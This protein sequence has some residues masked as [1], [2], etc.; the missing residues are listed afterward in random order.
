MD[1]LFKIS[2][3]LN[4]KEIAK[5]RK[6]LASPFFEVPNYIQEFGKKW[7]QLCEATDWHPLEKEEAWYGIYGSKPFDDRFW[8]KRKSEL[9]K[10][11]ERFI[12]QNHYTTNS[13]HQTVE[14][15]RQ[16]SERNLSKLFE[17]K[18]ETA[19]K[20]Q[21]TTVYRSE[22]DIRKRIEI[23][24]IGYNHHIN[25]QDPNKPNAIEG[26]LLKIR[27]KL[28]HDLYLFQN[29]KLKCALKN[30]K[31]MGS[32][33]PADITLDEDTKNE[34]NLETQPL[35]HLYTLLF[36]YLESQNEENFTEFIEQL[37]KHTDSL[38]KSER[39]SL[40]LYSINIS[41]QSYIREKKQTYAET[42]LATYKLALET[43]SLSNKQGKLIPGHFKNICSVS[44]R[45]RRW[46]FT[47]S[48]ISQ[49]SSSLTSGE[50]S[51]NVAEYCKALLEFS[52]GRF[53]ICLET[54][55]SLKKDGYL[56]SEIRMLEIKALYE[57]GKEDEIEYA[58]INYTRWLERSRLQ[59]NRIKMQLQRLRILN[60]IRNLKPKD[61]I[62]WN[63]ISKQIK[64][65]NIHD[66]EWLM[67]KLQKQK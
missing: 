17:S 5:F 33:L 49:Y 42:L 35:F 56:K 60:R 61:D 65:N 11:L 45:L 4:G 50:Q 16:L 29:L 55:K 43:N 37:K 40:F 9:T 36:E 52:K 26:K 34:K 13:S 41:I 1:K 39:T 3:S 59:P 8:R 63:N 53:D 57:L 32:I 58:I 31:T 38:D 23:A 66:K 21:L 6:F 27:T 24:E 48:F 19:F 30:R 18:F 54:L 12:V 2:R 46:D 67:E 25:R 62:E 51:E 20:Q 14:I 64:T 44:N 7:F 47:E 28:S 15:L 22:E 10:E